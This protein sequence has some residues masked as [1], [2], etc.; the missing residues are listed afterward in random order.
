MDVAQITIGTQDSQIPPGKGYQSYSL[1]M[2][3]WSPAELEVIKQKDETIFIGL[4]LR[5]GDGL[6]KVVNNYRYC[7]QTLY[8]TITKNINWT[9]CGPGTLDKLLARTHVEIEKRQKSQEPNAQPNSPPAF[10]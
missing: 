4:T 1:K 2:R 8:D 6:G 3:H 7:T 10:P 5:Y 9:D